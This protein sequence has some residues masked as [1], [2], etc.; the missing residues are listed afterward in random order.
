MHVQY[1]LQFFSSLISTHLVK[2]TGP[3][4]AS[5]IS[6]I[7][8]SFRLFN[9]QYPPFTP[10]SGFNIFALTKR[11]NILFT[12][13]IPKPVLLEILLAVSFLSWKQQS[14]NTE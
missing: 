10:R 13:A 2:A 12:V 6:F 7:D 1:K 5:I 4:I 14:I 11:D 9:G 3:S 8:T